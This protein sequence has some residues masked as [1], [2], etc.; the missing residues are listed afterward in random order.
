VHVEQKHANKRRR[1]AKF[2]K[3]NFAPAYQHVF[4]RE[5]AKRKVENLLYKIVVA[6]SENILIRGAQFNK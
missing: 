3:L 5:P 1:R 6:Q 2:N 4:A